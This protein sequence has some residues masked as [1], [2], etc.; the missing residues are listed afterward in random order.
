[1]TDKPN[2]QQASGGNTKKLS[3]KE[4]RDARLKK[5]LR[6][7]LQRRKAKMRAIKAA[8]KDSST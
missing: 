8:D 5:S 1:M 7:N 4:E 3:A 2:N 6:A